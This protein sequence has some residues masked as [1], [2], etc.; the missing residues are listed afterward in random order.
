MDMVVRGGVRGSVRGDDQRGAWERSILV[1]QVRR[2]V[3]DELR[4]ALGTAGRLEVPMARR[5]PAGEPEPLAGGTGLVPAYEAARDS[6][7]VLGPAGSGKTTALYELTAHLLAQAEKDPARAVPVVLNLASWTR[8]RGRLESWLVDELTA[9][10]EVP[11]ALARTWVA[12]ERVLPLLDGLDELPAQARAD[13]AEQVN[14]FR[15]RHGLVRLVLCSTEEAY[16]PVSRVLRLHEVVELR[17]L[18]RSTVLGQLGRAGL[19]LDAGQQADEGLW[20]LLGSPLMLGL[21]AAAY[22][23][24]GSPPLPAGPVEARRTAVLAAFVD[25]AMTPPAQP[26]AQRVKPPATQ[27]PERYLDVLTQLARAIRARGEHEL[28][29]DLVQPDW[30]TSQGGRRLV[31]ATPYL[32]AAAAALLLSLALYAPLAGPVPAL[33]L[34]ACALALNLLIGSQLRPPARFPIQPVE[35]ADWRPPAGLLHRLAPAQAAQAWAAAPEDRAGPAAGL[36]RSARQAAV[37]AAWALGLVLPPLTLLWAADRAGPFP[38]QLAVTVVLVV[39]VLVLP[40]AMRYGGQACC[41]HLAL[42]ALLV[43]QTQVPWRWGRLL[44]EGR[45]R[46]LLVRSGNGYRFAHRMLLDHLAGAPA[47]SPERTTAPV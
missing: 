23:G 5:R 17:P 27:P 1:R 24:Q 21:V 33:G 42:R 11:G 29:L 34:A 35:R 20:E 19:R 18:E 2:K 12:E 14:A 38:V 22:Q 30:L 45:R 31:L 26:A 44:E 13:C 16:A 36:E 25:R 15:R 7:L 28:R 9:G 6:M 37:A 10:Y 4:A 43:R 47:G 8:H 40:V 39:V 41:R 3:S 46:G 32:L